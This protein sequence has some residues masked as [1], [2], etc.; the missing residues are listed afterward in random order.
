MIK[1]AFIIPAYN[2]EKSIAKVIES[3]A[4]T[5][6]KYEINNYQIVVVSDGSKDKTAQ[7]ARSF[8]QTHVIE[9]VINMGAGAATR[10]GLLYAR[11]NEFNYAVTLDA[12]GQHL[13]TDVLK[14][15]KAVEAGNS[16]V[17]IGNRL[18]DKQGMPFIKRLGNWG[19]SFITQV[20][21]G[22]NI[23]DSQSGLRAFNNEAIQKINYLSNRYAFCSEMLWRLK[24]SNLS[25]KEVPINAIYT[26]YS[27][28]SG[29]GQ[30]NWGAFEIVKHM[31]IL[32]I[33]DAMK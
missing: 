15:L 12:D 25:V 11:Q 3:L 4:V 24:L 10:T 21:Y 16:D 27:K 23:K 7:V 32:R 13:S 2:E 31:L 20:I 17:V 9:H 8:Q 5:A 30:S 26:D 1:V 14:V 22:S 29:R 28:A 33:K 6:K 18:W 19:L